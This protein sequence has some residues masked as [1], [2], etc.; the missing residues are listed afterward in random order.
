[1][2]LIIDLRNFARTNIQVIP[3]KWNHF[4]LGIFKKNKQKNPTKL[5]GGGGRRQPKKPNPGQLVSLILRC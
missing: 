1:M 2:S 5:G 3:S 4:A